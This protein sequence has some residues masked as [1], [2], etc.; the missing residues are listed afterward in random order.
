MQ[1]SPLPSCWR[2]CNCNADAMGF[3]SLETMPWA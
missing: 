1:M 2:G 3:T